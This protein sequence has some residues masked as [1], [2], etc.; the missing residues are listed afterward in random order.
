MQKSNITT[1]GIKGAAK[2]ALVGGLI[3]GA[4]GSLAGG[5]GAIPGA[6]IGAVDGAIT[7]ATVGDEEHTLKKKKM[8]FKAKAKKKMVKENSNL[9]NFIKAIAEKN[10][11]VANK[12]LSQEIEAKLKARISA[13]I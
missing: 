12:Y 13:N 2:G 1:E 10:Y 3:G 8:K 7:G 11:S 9:L 5:I 6:A 4:E